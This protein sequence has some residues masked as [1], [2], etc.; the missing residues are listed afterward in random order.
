MSSP[1]SRTHPLE[2]GPSVHLRLARRGDLNAVLALLAGRGVEAT[3][4]EVLRL[5]SY[6]PA[7]RAVLCAYAPI[8]GRETLVGLAGC[9]LRRGAELDTLV[10]DA[11]VS[12]ALARLLSEALHA[13]ADGRGAIVA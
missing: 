5:L 3:A 12:A 13:R 8:D 10:V 1:F 6:D 7:L 2:D 4:L 11:R 9:D